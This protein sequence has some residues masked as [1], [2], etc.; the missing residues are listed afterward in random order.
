MK[1]NILVYRY[2]SICEPFVINAFKTHGCAVEEITEGMNNIHISAKDILELLNQRLSV[3]NYDAVFS[4]NFYP[5][6]SEVCN[7]YHIP[8]ICWTV[9]CPVFELYSHSIKNPWNRIFL[10][11]YAQYQEFYPQNPNC[12]F[13]LPLAA[14]IEHYDKVIQTI[15]EAD[16][17]FR[18]DISFVGSLYSEKSPYNKVTNLP[19][20][21][22]GYLD[23]LVES[24]L[25]IYGYNIL[26]EILTEDIVREYKK[27]ADFYQFPEK[28]DK[29][30]IAY[31]AHGILDYRVAELERTRLL[32]SLS[33]HFHVDLYTGSNTDGLSMVHNH[34]TVKTL[35]EMPKIF[36]LSKINLNFTIRA[37]QTGLPL[38][39]WDIMG[40]GGF[41]LSNYQQ[42][43]PEYFEIGKD[44]DTFGSE[45]E[46][47]EKAQ[48]YL[49]HEDERLQVAKNGYEKV[50][51]LHTW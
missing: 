18:G 29:N 26:P 9:D 17:H 13:Y 10:F 28:S 33:R 46:L 31:L 14:D 32:D 2:N 1:K 6:I 19:D 47:L 38:R 21:L 51:K 37:I 11:D 42:E 34:G 43:I 5:V 15:N 41:V 49:T 23:G 40:C 24:Q 8:Y 20:Y 22:K 39:I 30:E 35:T 3:S 44:L 4:I 16:E 48:Y 27:Y 45:S 12:I 36:H 7:I 50:K 25:Q